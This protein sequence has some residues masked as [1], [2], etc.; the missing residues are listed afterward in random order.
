MVLCV[1]PLATACGLIPPEGPSQLDM[2]PRIDS[3]PSA[4]RL[5]PD[6]YPLLGAFPSSAAAQLPDAE[7]VAERGQLQS[8]AGTQAATLRSGNAE[9]VRSVADSKAAQTATR[10]E[11]D[12][13]VSQAR[14]SDGPLTV[15][16]EDVLR[17]I[18]GR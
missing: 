8:A 1:A 12:A 10:Q 6:G 9:Y 17:E 15:T 13:A 5:G 3:G 11:V 16:S 18:E 14:G 4:Q 2:R 7:V